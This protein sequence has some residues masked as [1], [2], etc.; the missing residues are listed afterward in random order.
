M[1]VVQIYTTVGLYSTYTYDVCT[2]TF[3]F[4]GTLINVRCLTIKILSW[5]RRFNATY[6]C[7]YTFRGDSMF[8]DMKPTRETTKIGATQ[9]KRARLQ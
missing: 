8:A 2:V 4:R 9:N 3:Y 5:I 1:C 7:P 6:M